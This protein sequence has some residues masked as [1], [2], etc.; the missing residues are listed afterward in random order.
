MKEI[1]LEL[2]QAL[3]EAGFPQETY[4]MYR[5]SIDGDYLTDRQMDIEYICAAPNSDEIE[6]Q[7]EKEFGEIVKMV[8]ED[9]TEVL[10]LVYRDYS[11]LEITIR[12]CENN[13]EARAKLYLELKKSVN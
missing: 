3:K 2:A 5:H 11:F 1:T 4:R 6:A 8:W 9:K 12:N 13:L 7:I 10:F